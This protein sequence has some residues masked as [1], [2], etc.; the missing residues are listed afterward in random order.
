MKNLKI[1]V[2]EDSVEYHKAL[3]Y[4]M[5]PQLKLLGIS[6]YFIFTINSDTLEQDLVA[7][8]DIILVDDD[9]GN[10]YG[11]EIIAQ[12]DSF[13]EYKSIPIIYYSGG[14]TLEN[15]KLKTSKY[16][17]VMCTTKSSLGEKL[18]GICKRLNEKA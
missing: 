1:Y 10:F 13:P 9:L 12:I 8:V 15:L 14:E 11:D 5:E 4:E 3:S 7:G 16:G 6:P 18:K 2:I 17:S